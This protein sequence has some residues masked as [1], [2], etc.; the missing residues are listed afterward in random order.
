MKI[1]IN[2]VS[3][4]SSSSYIISCKGQELAEYV[5]EAYGKVF[6][7]FMELNPNYIGYGLDRENYQI[8]S[9]DEIIKYFK[10]RYMSKEELE[11]SKEELEKE[12]KK[13]YI[14]LF[15][16]SSSDDG[17]P[18]QQIID[19]FNEYIVTCL[20]G[21]YDWSNDCYK[22]DINIIFERRWS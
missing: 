4:S 9:V 10:E 5:K 16:N 11:Y 7:L 20:K 15:G 18:E 1:R 13:G 19:M 17:T 2:F 8:C 3:N 6:D 12:E 21:Q 14:F 22:N